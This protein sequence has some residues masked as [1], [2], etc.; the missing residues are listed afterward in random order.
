MICSICEA[1]C[2]EINFNAQPIKPGT[3][4]CSDCNLM[5]VVPAKIS[6]LTSKVLYDIDH[7]EDKNE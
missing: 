6:I 3:R 5:V 1:D 7:H 4:C 2:T